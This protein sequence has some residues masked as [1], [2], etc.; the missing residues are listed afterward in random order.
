MDFGIGIA[1]DRDAIRAGKEACKQ[2]LSSLKK[3]DLIILFASTIFDIEALVSSVFLA[4]SKAPMIGCTTSGEI[5]DDILFG[6]C[7]VVAVKCSDDEEIEVRGIED[8]YK[9]PRKAGQEIVSDEYKKG[10][11]LVLSD[12]L[13]PQTSLLVKGIN[14]Y[15]SPCISLVGA[16]AGD[17]LKRNKTYQFLNG[18]IFTQGMVSAFFKTSAKIKTSLRHGFS[19]QSPPLRVTSAKENVI[20]QIDSHR[21]SKVYLEFL[22]LSEDELA[23]GSPIDIKEVRNS[24][25]GIPQTTGDYKVKSFLEFRKDGS[26]ACD[27]YI[28]ENSIIRILGQNPSSLL[29]AGCEAISDAISEIHPKIIFL[30]PSSYRMLILGEDA[31][32]EIDEIKKEAKDVP[33]VGFYGYGEIGPL[34]TPRADFHNKSIGVLAIE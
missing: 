32:N 29:N 21:A 22:G 30:F 7:L 10:L 1:K 25:I 5:K 8:I 4:S 6:S 20:Y 9:N 27:S 3:P 18:K 19:P 14:D 15:L 33:I 11:L 26:I 28:P 23:F 12:G 24:P 2:A 13:F 16:L 31:R 17:D 34:R